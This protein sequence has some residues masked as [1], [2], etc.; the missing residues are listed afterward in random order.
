VFYTARRYDLMAENIERS[1]GRIRVA[2]LNVA[3]F[4]RPAVEREVNP[5][6]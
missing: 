4:P 1:A 5:P 2:I 3:S 6:G